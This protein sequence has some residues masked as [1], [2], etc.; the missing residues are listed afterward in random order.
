MAYTTDTVKDSQTT[1]WQGTN[2]HVCKDPKP[3]QWSEIAASELAAQVVSGS[4]VDA[5]GDVSGRKT[6]CPAQTGVSITAD[7]TA[8]CIVLSNGSNAITARTTT[9]PQALSTGGTVDIPAFDME[10]LDPT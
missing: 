6:T 3:T 10:M 1:Q 9:T 2:I 8:T 4:Y 5:D 7:G